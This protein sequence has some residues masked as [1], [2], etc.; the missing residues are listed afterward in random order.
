ML[1]NQ[2][3][4]HGSFSTRLHSR[5][6]MFRL[7]SRISSRTK[8]FLF[9]SRILYL[10]LECLLQL[11]SAAKFAPQEISWPA[12]ANRIGSRECVLPHLR[13]T[14]S[15]APHQFTS[16]SLPQRKR[17]RK[18]T[19]RPPN[20]LLLLLLPLLLRRNKAPSL[21]NNNN[22]ANN[23]SLMMMMTKSL[24]KKTSPLRRRI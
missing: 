7:S 22:L 17:N 1:R 2:L 5:E 16:T 20:R 8:L 23:R 11:L 18:T 10:L 6:E 9:A 14:T 3:K 24:P 21:V 19:T 4:H 12:V 13:S 15:A